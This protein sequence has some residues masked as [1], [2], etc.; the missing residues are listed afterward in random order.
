MEKI[1]RQFLILGFMT[2]FCAKA[3]T[4]SPSVEQFYHSQLLMPFTVNTNDPS[5]KFAPIMPFRK[6]DSGKIIDFTLPIN[7][8]DS[9]KLIP[10]WADDYFIMGTALSITTDG[11]LVQLDNSSL[12]QGNVVFLKNYP[13]KGSLIDG[14]AIFD[15]AYPSTNYT[16][17]YVTVQGNEATVRNILIAGH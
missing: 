6:V 7:S 10:Q 5:W 9:V 11:I 2:G 13:Y 15:V 16:Y 8:E 4:I 3:Q 1:R 12:N 17:K 14:D